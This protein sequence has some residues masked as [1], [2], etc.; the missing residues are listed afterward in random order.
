MQLRQQENSKKSAKRA[1]CK[2]A[3]WQTA[4][5][6]PLQRPRNIVQHGVNFQPCCSCAATV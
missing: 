3:N 1:C 6:L 5:P 4:V 2:V